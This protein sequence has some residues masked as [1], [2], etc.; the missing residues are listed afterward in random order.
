MAVSA[1]TLEP[2]EPEDL[3][4]AW[5]VYRA[6]TEPRERVASRRP[7]PDHPDLPPP[8]YAHLLLTSEGGFWVARYE[9]QVVG[10]AAAVNRGRLWWLSELWVAPGFRGR[11][12]AQG[13][14]RKVRRSSRGARGRVMAGLAGEDGI[15]VVLGL[16]A[17][18][19][20]RYPV[21]VLEGDADA[22]GRLRRTCNLPSGGRIARYDAAARMGTRSPLLRL[23]REVRDGGREEDHAFWMNRDGRSCFLLWKGNRAMAYGY[24]GPD[25]N[26][27][28]LA[29]GGPQGLK[30]ALGM[31]VWK[32]AK[33]SE[34]VRLR[35]PAVNASAVEALLGAGFR[36]VDHLLLM[37]SDDFGKMD[38]YL[39]AD[40]SLF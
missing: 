29:S 21:F 19:Q 36:I 17:G 23:D 6:S 31:M 15:G 22:A 10:F 24:V 14:L 34:T 11:G 30:G 32:A 1:A 20:A 9:G 27:G 4:G 8:L 16:R 39:P 5:E 3:P 12:I 25:G 26:V 2:A 37:A 7:S 18:M 33:I 35:V 13:L 40:E 38:R 28:P